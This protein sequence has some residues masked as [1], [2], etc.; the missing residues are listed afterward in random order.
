[1]PVTLYNRMR[2]VDN[3]YAIYVSGQFEFRV[4]KTYRQPKNE[5]TYTTKD[6]ENVATWYVAA[7]SP[8]TH[9]R[10]EYGDMYIDSVMEDARLV[11]GDISWTEDYAR[12]HDEQ[13][14]AIKNFRKGLPL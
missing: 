4:L 1:M 9:N 10:W 14:E 12:N 2:E 3:P 13:G 8:L 6:G 7:K 5:R 11:Y